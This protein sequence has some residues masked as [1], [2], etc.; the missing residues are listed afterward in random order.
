[1]DRTRVQQE[2]SQK[3]LPAGSRSPNQSLSAQF[4]LLTALV[5]P[6]IPQ[7]FWLLQT[8]SMARNFSLL[9]GTELPVQVTRN[10]IILFFPLFQTLLDVSL[11]AGSDPGIL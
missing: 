6:Q 8:T 11:G 10:E 9:T 3:N 4:P 5:S 1:M 7:I 2:L